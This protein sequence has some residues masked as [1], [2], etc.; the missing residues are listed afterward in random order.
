[1][2]SISLATPRAVRRPTLLPTR[3]FTP[4]WASV[5]R[6][7]TG[8]STRILTWLGTPRTTAHSRGS[9]RLESRVPRSISRAID[10]PFRRAALI[11]RNRHFKLM[12]AIALA[13]CAT[14]APAATA[15]PVTTGPACSACE[16]GPL[17]DFAR[18]HAPAGVAAT[19]RLESP[20]G[21][22]WGD[23]GIGGA[24]GV[25]L[26]HSQSPGA[27]SCGINYSRNS[28]DGKYCPPRH[29]TPIASLPPASAARAKVIVRDSGFA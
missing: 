1:M 25:A 8:T 15:R 23:A 7:R 3:R 14:A 17:V 28:V 16:Y 27:Y 10:R 29:A 18:V 21:F 19:V 11:L 5:R 2:G 6:R 9:E 13:L 22:D 26:H 4:I 20:R 12:L 24:A